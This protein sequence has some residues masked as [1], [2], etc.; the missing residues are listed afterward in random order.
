MFLHIKLHFKNLERCR[1]LK[2]LN[3]PECFVADCSMTVT[4]GIPKPGV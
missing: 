4:V 1:F 3:T 2:V